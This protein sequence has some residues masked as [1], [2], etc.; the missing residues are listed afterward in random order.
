MM[1]S[2]L[3]RPLVPGSDL[4]SLTEEVVEVWGGGGGGGGG[5]GRGE[6]ERERQWERQ[7]EREKVER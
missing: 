1:T 6:G 3:A 4:R 5:G 7:R 2:S